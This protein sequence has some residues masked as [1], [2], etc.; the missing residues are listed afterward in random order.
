MTASAFDSRWELVVGLE[1]HVQLKTR[2]KIFCPCPTDFGAPPNANT[3]PVCLAL[4]GRA[5]GAQ[6][7]APCSW[8]SRRRSRSSARCTAPRSSPA[9]TTSIPTSP[10]ATR[11]PS[12]TSRS[13]PADA[14]SI[15]THA[16]GHAARHR[17]HPRAHGGGCRKVGPRPLCRA[18]RHRPQS[19]RHAAGGDRQRARPAHAGR[20]ARVSACASRRSSS[21][22]R[23]P[24]R[25]WRRGACASMPTSACARTDR[26][27]WGPRPRSRT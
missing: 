19:R 18:L 9:R 21:T 16:D 24:T 17:H 4:P 2:T 10:R 6:R 23:C 11:S 26:R 27:R 7:A 1:V 12:S 3:C 22:P 15:G 25:T 13:P 14:W 8:R 5:P 20:G